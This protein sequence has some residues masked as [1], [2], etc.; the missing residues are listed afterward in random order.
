MLGWLS[1]EFEFVSKTNKENTLFLVL[2]RC[3]A[4]Y[5]QGI[6]VMFN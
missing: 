2:L 6:G 4:E 3:S 1:C 5:R